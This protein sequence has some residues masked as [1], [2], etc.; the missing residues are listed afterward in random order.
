MK[1]FT[2]EFDF[3]RYANLFALSQILSRGEQFW[4]NVELYQAC[5]AGDL[6]RIRS[7]LVQ[8]NATIWMFVDAVN[9][10]EVA[11]S[12][13]AIYHKSNDEH[14]ALLTRLSLLSDGGES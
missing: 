14:N 9:W 4:F 6:K 12:A 8:A 1:D 2:S 13:V 5:E 11:R 10:P 7:I 3:K